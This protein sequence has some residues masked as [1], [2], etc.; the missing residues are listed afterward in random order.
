LDVNYN[1]DVI[2]L[3]SIL[4]QGKYTSGKELIT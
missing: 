2:E 4:N 1:A 3:L